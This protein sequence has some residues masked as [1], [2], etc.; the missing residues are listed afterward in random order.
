M[1][2]TRPRIRKADCVY[3][4]VEQA[5]TRDH[6]VPKCLFSKPL[7]AFMVTAPVCLKCN[8]DKARDEQYLRDVLIVD[9]FSSEHPM[10]RTIFEG[11]M[12][13]AREHN[14]S[15]VA[16]DAQDA[17]MEPLHTQGG[18]YLGHYPTMPLDWER[19]SRT[20]SAMI[21]GLY[22]QLR[23]ETFPQ[24]YSTSVTR[25]HPWDV[26]TV[27]EAI[28]ASHFNGPYRLG[29]GV[30]ECVM[31]VV[32]EDPG[33]TRWLLRF[34]RNYVLLVTTKPEVPHANLMPPW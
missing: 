32:S 11:E 24:G 23:R 7:P 30:F 19:V 10:A 1:G 18:I 16:R 4:G 12:T 22:W 26:Q 27:W 21:R 13:R 9:I 5:T 8:Q 29:N 20:I 15:E 3:C 25:I 31:Q 34:Y 33:M 2:K 6:V 17:R 28:G 14:R